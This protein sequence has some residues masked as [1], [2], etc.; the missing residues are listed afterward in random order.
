LA[1][2]RA[3]IAMLESALAEEH[4]HS[5]EPGSPLGDIERVEPRLWNRVRQLRA[6]QDSL[7]ARAGML[8]HQLEMT[9][10]DGLDVADI[11]QSLEQLANELRYQ[12]ARETDLV[13]E[14]YHVDLGAGD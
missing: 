11:R 2:V 5:D 3:A 6:R 7:R 9:P 13:Y 14:A 8:A 1:D 12:R 10:V 4:G